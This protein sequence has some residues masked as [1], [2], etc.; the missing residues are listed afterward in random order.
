MNPSLRIV[1]GQVSWQLR[2]TAVHAAV[3]RLGGQLGPVVFRS[4][5]RDIQPFSVA[6]WAEEPTARRLP[7]ILR[8]LR[9]D[10]FCLPFGANAQAFRGE[11]HPLHGETA[12]RPW[13]FESLDKSAGRWTLHLSLTTQIRPGRVDKLISLVD[14][15]AAVY[16]RHIIRGLAGP[17]PLGHHAMLKFPE[18]PASGWITTSPFVRGQVFPGVFERPETG[19]YS[20]LKAGADFT[21]LEQVPGIDGEP[22]D[23]T[24]YPARE[25]FEDLVMVV[26]DPTLPLAWTAVTFPRERYVWFALK[27]PAVLRHTVFWFSNGGRHYPPWNGRHRHVLGIEDV[28]AYFHLGLAASAGRNPLSAHGHP[29]C[30][31]LRPDRPCVV[32]YVMAVASVPAG[33]DRVVSM[34]AATDGQRLSLQAFS[35]QRVE[36][37]LDLSFLRAAV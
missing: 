33:F 35:G 2:S 5:G 34:T 22:V 12:N 1:H 18:R 15:H 31:R 26:S 21:G 9:G 13:R 4:G 17:M 6:P 28:T 19:G 14:G 7:P 11:H 20:W 16:C 8:A 29:T 36:V 3:T 24:R 37:P 32:N 27:D 25:G 23:L 10:F 30:V